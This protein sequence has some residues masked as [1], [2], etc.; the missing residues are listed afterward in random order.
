MRKSTYT[1]AILVTVL[2]C[3]LSTLAL[4]ANTVAA[5]A[6]PLSPNDASRVTASATPGVVLITSK[7]EVTARLRY[8]DSNTI[9]GVG[10]I[11]RR[12]TVGT[13]SGTGF[14]VTP[15]GAIVTASHV[16]DPDQADV[17]HYATNMMF[18]SIF[19]EYRFPQP[20]D[21]YTITDNR[22]LNTLLRQCYSG[23]ACHFEVTPVIT[24][25]PTVGIGSQIQTPTP[26]PAQ[27]LKRTG[28]DTT[29]VA[30]LKV[31][32]ANMP[33]VPLAKSALNLQP[34]TQLDV[35]GFPGSVME[36]SST[37]FTSPTLVP[38][39]VSSVR[40]G[41]GADDQ[42]Q[43]QGDIEHGESGGPVLDGSGR[44]V[45]LVSWGF[46]ST[47]DNFLRTIDDIRTAL[48]ESGITPTAGPVDVA[49]A[50]AMNLY[51]NHHYTAAVPALRRV[52]D[53][54]A[55]NPMAQQYLA[56]AAALAG[57]GSDV[58]LASSSPAASGESTELLAGLGAALL[59]AAAA[60]TSML[61]LR[62]RRRPSR[63]LTGA[64]VSGD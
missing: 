24:V 13:W 36:T 1:R 3:L 27:I 37:G 15:T 10:T 40:P 43:V 35:L 49:Y 21:A 38:V 34:G 29:D 57:S 51:W 2:G 64:H 31:N 23:V 9:S 56:K 5:A 25:Y 18:H 22:Y 26:M 20:M 8:Q 55:G 58:P 30:V 50:R 61:V 7:F 46:D 63:G 48:G 32:G 6:A 47:G 42:I 41:V 14:V 28:F 11:T 19:P 4:V 59:L 52:L 44:V 33:T 62:G 16:V 17:R 45:G 60:G 54:D 39:T 53:L 12:Y